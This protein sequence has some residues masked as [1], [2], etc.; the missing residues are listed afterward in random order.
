MIR[1]RIVEFSHFPRHVR[2]RGKET[3]RA[4]LVLCLACCALQSVFCGF[5]RCI[6][7]VC[8][9][10]GLWLWAHR[11]QNRGNDVQA[12]ELRIQKRLEEVRARL[13][14]L[15]DPCFIALWRTM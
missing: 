15:I 7:L 1:K 3:K 11:R 12:K 13:L 9:C 14:V 8:G 4:C 2:A 10:V 6:V 5:H